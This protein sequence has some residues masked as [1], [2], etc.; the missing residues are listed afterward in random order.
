MDYKMLI[1]FLY[2]STKTQKI[3]T[4]INVQDALR[5]AVRIH[6][7]MRPLFKKIFINLR[8]SSV[9]LLEKSINSGYTDLPSVMAL[10][11]QFSHQTKM[12]ASG[13]DVCI[14]AVYLHVLTAHLA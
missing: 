12:K 14:Q 7:G 9:L 10:D 2:T 13:C 5:H 6:N 4:Q 3:Q 1:F 11:P 8:L